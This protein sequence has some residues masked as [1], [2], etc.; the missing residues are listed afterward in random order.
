[1]DSESEPKIADFG[2]AKL[3]SDDSDAS[4]TVPAIIGTLGY[5]APEYRPSTLL[6]EKCDVYTYGVVLLVLIWRKLPVDP[7]FEGVDI[8][9][10]TKKNLQADNEWCSF[11]DMEVSSWN[12]DEQWKVLKLL[13]LAMDC[14][15]LEPGIRPSMRDL[16]GYLLKLNAKHDATVYTK[17]ISDF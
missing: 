7:S 8:V 3:V 4:S 11:L 16:V 2:L 14:T 15:E 12:V 5:S 10:W 1:M 6:T 9:S 17:E 13:D